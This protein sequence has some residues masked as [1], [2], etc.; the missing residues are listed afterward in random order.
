MS[1]LTF[2]E[3][4]DAENLKGVLQSGGLHPETATA[5]APFLGE[6]A[7][8]LAQFG[9]GQRTGV[10]AFLIPGR[11]EVLGKH[12]DYGGGRSI[13]T[14]VEQGFCLVAVPRTDSSVNVVAADTGERASFSLDPELVVPRG[15][16][17]NY[18]MTVARRLARNFPACRRGADI[19]FMSDLP[20]ATGM[21][22][23]SAL[24]VAAYLVLAGVNDLSVD[25][26]YRR[27]ISDLLSL[28]AY[29]GTIE[30][31]QSF[32]DLEGDRGV[33]TFGGSEDHTAILC[34]ESGRLG[35][36]A[37]CPTRLERYIEMPA[38]YVFA[39]GV[40]GVVAEKTGA[41]LEHYNRASSKVSAVVEAWRQKTGREDIYLADIISSGPGALVNLRQILEEVSDGPHSSEDLIQR[42]DHFIA[43][44]EEI[45]GPAGDALNAGDMDRFGRLVDRSQELTETLLC[46]QVPQ[47]VALARTARECGAVAASAFGAGFGGS[48]WAMVENA[49]KATFLERWSQ[50]YADLHPGETAR[51]SFFLTR[52][53]PPAFELGESSNL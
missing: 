4:E 44:N 20:P 47:T 7:K 8:G 38:G 26:S 12:T 51:A 46:N 19:A 25:K 2:K 31:G 27:N 32:A 39:V 42:L 5:K 45:I 28:A 53:G 11:I 43:E 1:D 17:S 24:I 40:S 36:F 13:V 48:V 23:S 22:S 15:H 3:M 37:Y 41:A 34:S 14:A 6:A 21:S 16:W 29:L 30:N 50:K 10:R 9:H 49:D 52:P 18:P 33:G 35:Q